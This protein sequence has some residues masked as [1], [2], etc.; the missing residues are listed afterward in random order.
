MFR[1]SDFTSSF[2]RS[3]EPSAR[4]AEM[5][6]AV[7]RHMY[8]LRSMVCHPILLRP[9]PMYLMTRKVTVVTHLRDGACMGLSGMGPSCMH[10]ESTE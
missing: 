2:H 7:C 3:T 10:Y 1:A 4:V 8:I 6:V 5:I 9:I